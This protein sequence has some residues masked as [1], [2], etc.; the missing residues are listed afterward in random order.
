MQKTT[1]MVIL[2]MVLA[3]ALTST[4]LAQMR[5]LDQP[6]GRLGPPDA[7]H[8]FPLW[9]ED[10]KGVQLDLPSPPI[11]DGVTAPTM[12]FDPVIPGNAF[13]EATGFGGEAFFHTAESVVD[14]LANGGRALLVL[15]IEAAYGAEDPLAGDQFLFAR[16]RVRFDTSVTGTY[17]VT[18]PWG[19]ETLEVTADDLGVLDPGE[20]ARF[21]HTNDWGGFAPLCPDQPSCLAAGVS[22]SAGF[23][24]ILLSPKEWR[25]LEA[26][27]MAAGV[28]PA[29]W[30]GD[31]VT[32]TT[33][34]GGLNGVN[35]FTIVG[36]DNAFGPGVNTVTS[37]LFTVS[38]HIFAGDVAPPPPGDEEPP[39][40]GDEE[41]PPADEEPP[42][43]DDGGT[44]TVQV[45][46]TET[47]VTEPSDSGTLLDG[48]FFLFLTN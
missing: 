26:D 29:E 17:T 39:P 46:V 18:H 20:T 23:E 35:S 34:T 6:L 30:I 4:A 2:A 19:V 7:T 36:P 15:A 47:T 22:E 12:I 33:V 38:G 5:P 45:V 14:G 44:D 37:D 24:R 21:S 28:D 1:K 16:V 40:P 11:G 9:V 25:F 42:P 48:R 32:E 10:S 31:G 41:P 3:M 13:S 27:T 8:G 43:A